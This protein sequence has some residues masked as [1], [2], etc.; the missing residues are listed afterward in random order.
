MTDTTD[1]DSGLVVLESVFE[2]FLHI[3][4]MFAIS[5]VDEVDDDQAAEVSQA[6]LTGCFG[7]RFHVRFKGGRFHT[8]FR[9]HFPRVNIDGDQRFGTVYDDGAAGGQWN[10]IAVEGLNLFFDLIAGENRPP[11]LVQF[12]Q[13]GILRHDRLEKVF[14][15]LGYFRIVH[16]HFIDIRAEI[17]AD[18]ANNQ[19]GLLVDQSRRLDL[20]AQLADLFVD[21]DQIVDVPFELGL[22]L[23][24]TGGTDDIT[25][26]FRQ[27]HGTHGLLEFFSRRFLFDF[28]GD[29]L[30]VA[31]RHQDHIA[32]R[33]R[34]VGGQGRPFGASLLFDDL[35]QYFLPAS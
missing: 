12:D 32:A 35:H 21:P 34:Q 15:F 3:A 13:L 25:D 5:H 10:L 27:I 14:A 26:I 22:F 19:V 11:L 28:A 20:F 31:F 24:D 33:Q 6:Q 9:G 29:A 2:A 30:G 16:Q 18:Q 4:D 7:G 17:I 23:A 8:L 1:R